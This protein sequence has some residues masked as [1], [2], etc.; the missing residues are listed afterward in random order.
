MLNSSG[1]KLENTTVLGPQSL[2]SMPDMQIGIKELTQCAFAFHTATGLK[3]QNLKI[4]KLLKL[5]SVLE[6]M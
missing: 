6:P 3:E 1:T 4:L 5:L 2:T